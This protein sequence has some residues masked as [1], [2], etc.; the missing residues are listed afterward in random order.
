LDTVP[1]D[2]P[3]RRATSTT[4]ADGAMIHSLVAVPKRIKRH[5]QHAVGA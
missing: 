4:L 5:R 1:T 2:T 3:A